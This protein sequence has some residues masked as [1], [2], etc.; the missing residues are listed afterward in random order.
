VALEFVLNLVIVE[1][2]YLGDEA[3]EAEADGRVGDVVSGGEILEGTG[4]KDETLDEGEVFVLEE[5]DPALRI[6]FGTF[7]YFVKIDLRINFNKI[8]VVFN[9]I[10]IEEKELKREKR[11][12][13]R[14]AIIKQ[15]WSPILAA[16]GFQEKWFAWR[17]DRGRKRKAGIA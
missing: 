7:H 13:N 16:D 12:R 15:C 17:T 1:D 5:V 8:K 9:Y 10:N 6:G 2:F 14:F 4:E 11:E 3:I